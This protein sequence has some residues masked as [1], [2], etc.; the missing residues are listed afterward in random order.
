MEN[1]RNC[2]DNFCSWDF[3]GNLMENPGSRRRLA[4][5]ATGRARS[6]SWA[7]ARVV[8][9]ATGG[10]RKGLQNRKTLEETMGKH[11]GNYGLTMVHD[12]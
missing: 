11:M 12:R 9:A 10:R 8:L 6:S 7:P 3:K 4:A 1:Y 2:R 5:L